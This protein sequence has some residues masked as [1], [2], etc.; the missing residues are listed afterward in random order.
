MHRKQLLIVGSGGK[1]FRE[2][3]LEAMSRK[4]DIVLF[5]AS[6]V[7]WQKHYVVDSHVVDVN[8][9]DA[10][11]GAACQVEANGV[12]TYDESLVQT[13]ADLAARLNLPHT[14]PE[15]IRRCKDKSAL[16][17]HLAKSDLSPVEFGVADGVEEA[18]DIANR[19]GYPVV[20]KPLALG[21]SIGVIRVDDEA[22]LVE[23]FKIAACAKANDGTRS[24]LA[25]VLIEEYLD[26]PEYSVDCVTW[27][28]VTHPMVVAEK[29]LAF[30]PYFEELAHIVPAE[31]CPGLDD[32]VQLVVDA[33]QAIGLDRLATHAEFKLTRKG[34][35]IIEINARLGGDLI[36]YLGYLA[37]GADVAGAV[38]DVSVGQAPDLTTTHSNA[39]SIYMIYPREACRV[40]GVRLRRHFT[41]YP[42]LEQL[43]TFVPPG[44]EVRLPPE[45]F[46]SRVSFA[47]LTG[48]SRE[49]CLRRRAAVE[50]DLIVDG[51][52]I[53]TP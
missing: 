28:G 14:N 11:F 17:A 43:T 44:T 1:A 53:V 3:A 51:S 34:P 45:G 27:E 9:I 37:T 46:L 52:P 12:L 15:A 29:T 35:R 6:E 19:I 24:K 8:D 16:R 33:H 32:A 47:I 36:P 26:G 48:T 21:G 50:A 18:G 7:T 42:G 20:F 40:D 49:E 5:D 23:A 4:V 22:G 2:Y 30:P 39:A 25:G 10:L 41:E 38:A 13:T 31:Q